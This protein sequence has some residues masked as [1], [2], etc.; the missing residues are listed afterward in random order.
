MHQRESWK[1]ESGFSTHAT[2][3]LPSGLLVAPM[4]LVPSLNLR[5]CFCRMRWKFLEISMS[6][7]IPPTWPRNSTAVTFAPRRCHTDPCRMAGQTHVW[8][9][10]LSFLKK[11]SWGRK[12]CRCSRH[13]HVFV[14]ESVCSDADQL[15][16]D[17]SSSDHN[18]LLWYF[19][20]GKSSCRWHDGLFI[21]LKKHIWTHFF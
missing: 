18:Q 4:T 16:P 21:N 6:M 7:P 11:Q 1:S 20:Q 12:C 9:V 10:Q 3:I 19:L 13:N 17:D 14:G 8:Q 15:H 5:P 2:S